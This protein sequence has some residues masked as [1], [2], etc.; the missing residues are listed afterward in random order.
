M[1]L[2]A[3]LVIR[4]KGTQRDFSHSARSSLESRFRQLSDHFPEASHCELHL[5]PDHLEFAAV[6]HSRGK[7]TDLAAHASAG[8]PRTAGELAIEKLERELR[9]E[10][11][12]RIFARRREARRDQE[13][14]RAN[15]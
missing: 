10:H 1:T 2:D 14:R 7:G 12:K 3:T 9:R 6:A 11:D 8:D 4:F 15:P 13:R 5:T